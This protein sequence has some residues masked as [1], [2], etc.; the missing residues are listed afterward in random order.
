MEKYSHGFVIPKLW[1]N[2]ERINFL[3]LGGTPSSIALGSS[4]ESTKA[5]FNY[6]SLRLDEKKFTKPNLFS[7]CGKVL[8]TY[9]SLNRTN[10][11]FSVCINSFR[12]FRLYKN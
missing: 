9:F 7:Q 10:F 3:K 12:A 1:L 11:V 6:I 5:C 8:P 2:N 4:Y